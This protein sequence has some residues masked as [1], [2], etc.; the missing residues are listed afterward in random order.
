MTVAEFIA[1][2]ANDADCLEVKDL[3]GNVLAS[4][5]LVGTGA[6]I[7][8]K[9]KYTD[10]VYDSETVVVYGDVTG[11]GLVNADDYS[12]AKLANIIPGTYNADNYYFFVANDVMADGYIDALDSSYINLMVR[13]YK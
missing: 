9:S 3:E 8:L 7:T 12:K 11:D 5:D 1:M 2:F 10:N 13:G 6:V 4:D